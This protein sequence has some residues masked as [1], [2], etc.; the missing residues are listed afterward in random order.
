MVAANKPTPATLSRIASSMWTDS[1]P[2]EHGFQ[3]LRI[4]GALPASLHGTLYRNGPGQFGQFGKRYAHPFEADGAATAIRIAGGKALGASRI[5]ASEGLVQE[6]AAGRSLFNLSV[7]WPRRLLNNLRGRRKNTAN[8]NIMVWQDRLFALMEAG[9]P[10]ELDPE[11]LSTIGETDLGVIG[12]MFSA[13]PHRVA[14]RKAAYNFG[15]SYGRVNQA[16]LYELPDTGPVRRLGAVDLPGAAMVHDFI[17][18]ETHLVF[19]L[20]PTRIDVPR[21]L[22]GLGTFEQIFRWRP[23]HGTEVICVPID[24]PT[25]VLRFTT[26]A[27]FQWH[28]VN[29]FNRANELVIDYVRYPDFRSFTDIG[30]AGAGATSELLAEGRYHR[31]TID[32]AARTLRSEQVSDRSCEFPT[33]QPGDEGRE[34]RIAYA[35]FD[36]LSAV[37]SIDARGKIIA[38]ELP[39]DVR[40][41]EPIYVDGHML[42]LCHTDGA[43]YVAVYDAARIPDGPVAKI[44]LDHHVPITFH[45]TF[46]PTLALR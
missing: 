33:L 24:R 19:F 38:H 45:G 9:R 1:L 41:T 39:D 14:S 26:D 37:G 32:L 36:T 23:E 2:R 43:A 12:A 40:A 46:H 42:S 6:R 30:R 4:E 29:A 13:H 34:H 16:H 5:H 25:D 3:P 20:S 15:L 27:F 21:M 44:W 10:T 28:F 11:D 35:T 31:A 7:S 17:A 22:L 18:T 8:T